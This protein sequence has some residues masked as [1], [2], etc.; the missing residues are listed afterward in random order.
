ME[1]FR[2]MNE[3]RFRV[4]PD[5]AV[6]LT[7]AGK[8]PGIAAHAQVE[9]LAFAQQ[10]GADPRRYDRLIGAALEGDKF[11]FAREDSV[12]AAW[13]VVDPILDDTTP[14]YAYP[15]GTW[16]PTAA[17]HLLPTGT[18]WRNPGG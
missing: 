8:K 9:E 5:T 10:P 18:S 7:L 12:E 4:R 16:G 15:P 3:L 1:E 6:S 17:D 14:V 2:G 13:H 11:Y